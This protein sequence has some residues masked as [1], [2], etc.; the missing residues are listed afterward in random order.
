[1]GTGDGQKMKQARCLEVSGGHILKAPPLPEEQGL[2]NSTLL[3]Y[4]I[5]SG[6]P[7]LIFDGVLEP[8]PQGGHGTC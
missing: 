8:P 5:R 7:E 3:R 4:A 1:M 6:T 2:Q